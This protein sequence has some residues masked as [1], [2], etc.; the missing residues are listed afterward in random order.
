MKKVAKDLC[1]KC[2][3]DFVRSQRGKG[4]GPV[5]KKA[6]VRRSFI[7]TTVREQRP[8]SHQKGARTRDQ[9]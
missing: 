8:R 3:Y 5:K 6:E 2:V 9:P 1:R 7:T 4:T